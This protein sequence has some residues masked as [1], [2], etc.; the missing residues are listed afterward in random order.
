MARPP[1][2]LQAAAAADARRPRVLAVLHEAGSS[3]G[4][5]G[6]MLAERG[7]A[8]DVRK[9]RF[10]DPLPPAT[11]DLAGVVLFGGNMSVNDPDAYLREET[12]WLALPLAAG[13]PLLGI[14]L[15]AQML[16]RHLG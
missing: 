2:R 13:T 12:D 16:A 4:R 3:T 8:V 9:P 14:C 1:A 10:G 11:D 7:Y 6:R 15:G 5:I